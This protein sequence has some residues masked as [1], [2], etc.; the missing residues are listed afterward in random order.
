MSLTKELLNNT[1][2]VKYSKAI[3]TNSTFTYEELVFGIK[4]YTSLLNKYK[5]KVDRVGIIVKDNINENTICLVLALLDLK[6][7][8]I[9]INEKIE[10]IEEILENENIKISFYES[11]KKPTCL[12]KCDLVID[13][14]YKYF[15]TARPY[16]NVRNFYKIANHDWFLNSIKSKK[17]N[18]NCVCKLYDKKDNETTKVNIYE[19]DL[20]LYG[21]EFA[22][23]TY[24]G[25]LQVAITTL[26]LYT[27]E[28]L[29]YATRALSNDMHL[30]C[31]SG[32]SASKKFSKIKKENPL[33]ISFDD[34]MLEYIVDNYKNKDFDFLSIEKVIPNVKKE[35]MEL[36]NELLKKYNYS[37]K[38][39]DLEKTLKL[40]K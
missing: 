19:E 25:R 10:N 26:P 21:T 3:T 17:E 38:N 16:Y 31:L 12:K 34:N 28:G 33:V 6:I 24:N 7:Q 18:E 4:N 20:K 1:Y 22:K 29:L 32:K 36:L 2:D 11:A 37:E 9:I 23:L 40:E 35:N 27:K 14:E 5:N 30:I 13:E 39:N 15:S 8:P